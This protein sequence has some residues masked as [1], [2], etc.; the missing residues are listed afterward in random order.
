MQYVL[1]VKKPGKLKNI[2]KNMENYTKGEFNHKITKK[3]TI[4]A[5]NVCHQPVYKLGLI[6]KDYPKLLQHSSADPLDLILNFLF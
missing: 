1:K 5:Q 2:S 6:L 3:A 4:D